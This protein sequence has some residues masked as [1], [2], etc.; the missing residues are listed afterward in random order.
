MQRADPVCSAEP[1]RPEAWS[2]RFMW[3]G[4]RDDA[5]RYNLEGFEPK[6]RA[7]LYTYHQD[8]GE[9]C[10]DNVE[11]GFFEAG[12]RHVIVQRVAVNDVGASNAR[13]DVWLDG[14]HVL[15]INDYQLRGDVDAGVGLVGAIYWGSFRGGSEHDE[16]WYPNAESA[17]DISKVTAYVCPGDR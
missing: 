17:V 14:A 2:A 5:G 12:K 8:R 13:L 9:R 16:S 1:I 3:R 15:D 7:V 11:F 10:G 4:I 6:A